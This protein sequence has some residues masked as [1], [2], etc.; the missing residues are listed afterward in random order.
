[1]EAKISPDG[2]NT[3]T[4][5]ISHECSKHFTQSSIVSVSFKVILTANLI[6]A[7]NDDII[8]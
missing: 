8:V 5:T 6:Q 7:A 1:M 3:S 4:T 2:F